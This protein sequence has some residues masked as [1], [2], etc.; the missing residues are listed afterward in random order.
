MLAIAFIGLKLQMQMTKLEA[1]P[2]TVQ[3]APT[4]YIQVPAL[5]G[6]VK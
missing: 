2:D 1:K 5:D 6:G 4:V 3:P